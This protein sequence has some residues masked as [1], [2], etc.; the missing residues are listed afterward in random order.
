MLKDFL[1]Q[2]CDANPDKYVYREK[3]SGKF[4][5]GK[6]CC[7]VVVRNGFSYL[8]MLMELTSFLD[9]QGFEDEDLEMSNTAMDEMGLDIIVYFPYS[10][11]A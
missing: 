4:M 11:E 5:F 6:T 2:F 1:K 3:Y 8:D 9:D 10:K 7:A